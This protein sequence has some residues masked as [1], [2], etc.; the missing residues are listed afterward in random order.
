MNPLYGNQ[1]NDGEHIWLNTHILIFDVE[2]N[3]WDGKKVA[4]LVYKQGPPK[5]YRKLTPKFYKVR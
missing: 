5:Q 2:K 1:A 4:V 3:L